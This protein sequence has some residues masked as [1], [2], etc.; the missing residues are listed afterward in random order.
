MAIKTVAQVGLLRV[1]AMLF[2]DPGAG[3]TGVFTEFTSWICILF[4]VYD[5]HQ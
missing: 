2:F 4:C 3:Y 1:L 5:A